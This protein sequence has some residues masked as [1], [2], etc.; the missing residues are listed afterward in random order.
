MIF[1]Y[2]SQYDD[3]I[4]FGVIKGNSKIVFIKP[5]LGGSYLGYEEKYLKIA[6]RLHQNFGCSVICVSN[7]HDN[8]K[9]IDSDREI[10][11]QYIS[12]NNITHAE[13]FYFGHSNG[14]IKGLELASSGI[15]FCK[16]LLVNMPLMINLHKTK[17]YITEIPK[18]EIIAIY[19]E[20]D[21]SFSY[22]PFLDGLFENV[23]ISSFPQADHHFKG[24]LDEFISLSDL[25][26]TE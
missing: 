25:L 8:K 9:H 15:S 24:F 6:M 20:K 11:E 4:E 1:D 23:K 12:D 18:T 7:P 10:I 14:G 22:T 3:R 21:P 17:K 5:G 26:M 19:G 16:M 2:V 13:L